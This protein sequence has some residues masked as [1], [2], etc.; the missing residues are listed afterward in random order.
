MGGRIRCGRIPAAEVDG[1]RVDDTSRRARVRRRGACARG[2]RPSGRRAR[3]TRRRGR[4]PAPALGLERDVLVGAEPAPWR[5]RPSGSPWSMPSALSPQSATAQPRRWRESRGD[6]RER[7]P[8]R[9]VELGVRGVHQRV[10]AGLD[11]GRH[12]LMSYVPV[13]P[14][15]TTSPPTASCARPRAA[16]MRLGGLRGALGAVGSSPTT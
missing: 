2:S 12:V 13:P 14:A 11:L 5:R 15:E 10:R 8:E 6:D 1:P 9:E 16:A 7:G 3:A 4:R